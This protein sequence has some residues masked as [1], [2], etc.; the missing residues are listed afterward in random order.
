MLNLKQPYFFFEPNPLDP[1]N[2]VLHLHL[3]DDEARAFYP[4]LLP[5]RD[6]LELTARLSQE[7]AQIALRSPEFRS[8][9]KIK[10]VE[11]E[12]PEDTVTPACTDARQGPSRP[13]RGLLAR[14]LGRE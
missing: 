10:D 3:Y 4:Y 14:I 11:M 1:A 8:R 7:V 5:F 13:P 12:T 6:A 2:P 9:V